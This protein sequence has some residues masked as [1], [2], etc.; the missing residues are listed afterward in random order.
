MFGAIAYGWKS[1]LKI[2]RGS[3]DSDVY[4]AHVTEVI[5]PF[6]NEHQNTDSYTFMQDGASCHVSKKSMAFLKEHNV[7]VMDWPAQSCDM[8]PIENLWSIIMNALSP[9]DKADEATFIRA[10]T[11]I[12]NEIPIEVINKLIDSCTTRWEAVYK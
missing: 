4:I 11:R 12:W 9:E 8:N 1:P 7:A 10:V 6:V 3:V 2:Y 5:L